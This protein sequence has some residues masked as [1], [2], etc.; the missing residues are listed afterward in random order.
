MALSRLSTS[1]CPYSAQEALW[2][3][4]HEATRADQPGFPALAC[5][6][7]VFLIFL[8]SRLPASVGAGPSHTPCS[9]QPPVPHVVSTLFFSAAFSPVSTRT[10]RPSQQRGRSSS[11]KPD[12]TT[13]TKVI[14]P[15]IVVQRSFFFFFFCL[16]QSLA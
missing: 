12:L 5:P 16:L 14:F 2:I 9:S 1:S 13:G 11:Q 7:C 8:W 6:I 15:L 10:S 3:L 4:A